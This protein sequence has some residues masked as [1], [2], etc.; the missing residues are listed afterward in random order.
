MKGAAWAY[1]ALAVWVSTVAV[2]AR[3]SDVTDLDRV[4]DSFA[5]EAATVGDGRV[6]LEVRGL[7]VNDDNADLDLNGFPVE[8]LEQRVGKTVKNMQG[9]VFDALASYGLGQRSEVGA[10]LP[11]FVQ[12]TDFRGD[13][14]DNDHGIGD[15]ELYGKFKRMVATNCALAGGLELQLPT[16]DEKKTFGTGELG[17]N[18][19]LSSR[20]QRG[21]IGVGGHIGYRIYTGRPDDEFNWGVEVLLRPN[22]LVLFR[23][24]VSGRYFK[25]YGDKFN[26]VHLLPGLDISLGE[27]MFLRPTVLVG[28]SDETANWGGGLGIAMMF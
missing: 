8:K 5:R 2:S 19:F 13:P 24:E 23:T 21:P 20:Y 10:I 7:Y 26:D 6:R 4:Y 16:G 15:L 12:E 9:G 22:D 3:G 18:P 17:F 27:N 28:L 11:F 14:S 25:S 1:G